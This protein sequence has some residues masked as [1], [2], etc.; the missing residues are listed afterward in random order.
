MDFTPFIL[1]CLTLFVTGAS[2]GVILAAWSTLNHVIR[3]VLLGLTILPGFGWIIISLN[4][5]LDAERWLMAHPGLVW[6]ITSMILLTLL[7][8]AL[9]EAPAD[10]P[11][12]PS[13]GHM[14]RH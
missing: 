6:F 7:R 3:M 8:L 10:L 2:V 5:V 9:T 4:W 13:D 11:T 14:P 12:S 1:M